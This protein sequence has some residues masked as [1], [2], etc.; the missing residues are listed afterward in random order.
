M[1]RR[2]RV[3]RMAPKLDPR[4]PLTGKKPAPATYAA[5][6]VRKHLSFSQIKYSA[7]G[8]CSATGKRRKLLVKLVLRRHQ[9][10]RRRPGCAGAKLKVQGRIALEQENAKHPWPHQN[11]EAATC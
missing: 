6:S 9:R 10:K 8:E 4:R 11:D 5:P 7:P 1:L 2:A 3:I